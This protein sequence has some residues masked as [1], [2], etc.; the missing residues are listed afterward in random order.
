AAVGRHPL[1]SS[2][3]MVTERFPRR[4]SPITGSPFPSFRDLS[5]ATA[6]ALPN[7]LRDKIAAVAAKMARLRLLR[8][9]ALTILALT[10]LLGL[11]L[12]GD[13]ALAFG[14]VMRFLLLGI[15]A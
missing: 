10:A 11:I 5:M 4:I 15:W 6:A 7:A 9:I 14:S 8:R 3:N 13:Y 12:L 1:Q 2:S